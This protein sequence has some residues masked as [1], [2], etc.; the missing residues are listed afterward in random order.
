VREYS[1]AYS[2]DSLDVKSAYPYGQIIANISRETTILELCSI[3]GVSDTDRRI[4]GLNLTGG[5]VNSVEFMTRAHK[6]PQLTELLDAFLSEL[7]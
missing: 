2:E 5:S 7:D 6:A 4:I 1:C 3:Q